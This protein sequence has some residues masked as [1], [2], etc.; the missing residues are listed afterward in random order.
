MANSNLIAAFLEGT[1]TKDVDKVVLTDSGDD[2]NPT[3][4]AL[5]H[6]NKLHI[7][8]NRF[9]EWMES[10]S[11]YI[12]QRV[13]EYGRYNDVTWEEVMNSIIVEVQKL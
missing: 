1:T 2:T 3:T 13:L 10:N 5:R 4:V 6:T 9:V 8:L 11:R 7:Y 12:I